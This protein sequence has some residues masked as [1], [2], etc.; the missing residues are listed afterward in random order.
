VRISVYISVA[1][2]IYVAIFARKSAELQDSVYRNGLITSYS[3]TIALLYGQTL[4]EYSTQQL[5]IARAMISAIILSTT[6]IAY[7]RYLQNERQLRGKVSMSL[8]VASLTLT[9]LSFVVTVR[10]WIWHIS[11]C[12]RFQLSLTSST[13]VSTALFWTSVALYTATTL[14][15][16]K[17]IFKSIMFERNGKERSDRYKTAYINVII[18]FWSLTFLFDLLTAEFIMYTALQYEAIYAKD[19]STPQHWGLGQVIALVMLAVPLWDIAYYHYEKNQPQVDKALG[20][21]PLVGQFYLRVRKRPTDQ[22]MDPLTAHPAQNIVHEEN[23]DASDLYSYPESTASGASIGD[24]NEASDGEFLSN[25]QRR[26][27]TA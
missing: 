11:A 25:S 7:I 19:S 27:H 21:A 15:K 12:G 17:R 3:I 26:I 9:I 1:I 13:E 5:L 14:L 8:N 10:T 4:K 2:A 24:G 6:C 20:R 23:Q 22:E 16:N 18:A